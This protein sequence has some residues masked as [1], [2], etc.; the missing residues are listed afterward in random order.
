MIKVPICLSVYLSV[1]LA[2]NPLIK[3]VKKFV[4]KMLQKNPN[5]LFG[6][7]SIYRVFIYHLHMYREYILYKIEK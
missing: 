1:C 4:C 3:L 6:D 2:V 5:E 7:H